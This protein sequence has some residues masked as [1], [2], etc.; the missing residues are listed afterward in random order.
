[1]PCVL[2]SIKQRVGFSFHVIQQRFLGSVRRECLDHF[3][4]L[5]EKQLYRLRKH[6]RCVLQSS[7]TASIAFTKDE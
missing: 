1:V 7:S 5:H 2:I 6:V 3:L 4:V